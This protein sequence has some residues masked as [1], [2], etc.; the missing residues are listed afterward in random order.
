MNLVL[1][2]RHWVIMTFAALFGVTGYLALP[3]VVPIYPMT[4]LAFPLI[5]IAASAT[6]QTLDRFPVDLSYCLHLLVGFG[7]VEV[8]HGGRLSAMGSVRALVVVECYPT[9]DAGLGL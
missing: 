7:V 3:V 9:P 4:A 1:E 8:D 2:P 6:P 5:A